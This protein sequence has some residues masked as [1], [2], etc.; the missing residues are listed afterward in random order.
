MKVS[1]IFH[2]IVTDT[3][4][5]SYLP[6]NSEGDDLPVRNKIYFCNIGG[7]KTSR[8]GMFKLRLVTYLVFATVE[9]QESQNESS[10][11]ADGLNG[12]DD[13][14]QQR[15]VDLHRRCIAAFT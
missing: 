15:I 8:R 13:H 7:S 4:A 14:P 10:D 2:S 11:D 9:N 12:D 5:L 1:A 3:A 6:V